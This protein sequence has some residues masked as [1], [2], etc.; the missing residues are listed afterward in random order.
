[1]AIQVMVAKRKTALL[2]YRF[3]HLKSEVQAARE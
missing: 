2:I 3:L 1:M